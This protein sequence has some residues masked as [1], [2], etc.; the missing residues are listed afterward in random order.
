M[1]QLIGQVLDLNVNRRRSRRTGAG[2]SATDRYLDILAIRTFEQQQ[3]E[4]FCSLCQNSVI[5]R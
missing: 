4:T 2:Y 1:Y 5:N 3:L